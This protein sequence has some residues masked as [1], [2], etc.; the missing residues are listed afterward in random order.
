MKAPFAPLQHLPAGTD[1]PPGASE[2]S[3]QDP[4]VDWLHGPEL[5]S[6]LCLALHICDLRLVCR[7][8][9]TRIEILDYAKEF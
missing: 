2:A 1:S 3:S 6:V 5:L 7:F 9:R 4:A 8:P